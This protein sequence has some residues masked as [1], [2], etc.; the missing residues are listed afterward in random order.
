MDLMMIINMFV[1]QTYGNVMPEDPES[2]QR[3]N[4]TTT[5]ISL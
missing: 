2:W 1:K 4:I 3:V 5:I